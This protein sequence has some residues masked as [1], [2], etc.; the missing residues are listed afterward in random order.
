MFLDSVRKFSACVDSVGF[1]AVVSADVISLSA[2]VVDF[3]WVH[4]HSGCFLFL[5]VCSRSGSHSDGWF[6]GPF[7]SSSYAHTLLSFGR[8]Y[9]CSFSSQ[10][11]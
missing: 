9:C 1:M 4:R 11:P 8:W 10:I 2:V 5:F 6:A 3:L 7:D